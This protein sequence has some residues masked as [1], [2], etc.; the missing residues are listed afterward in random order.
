MKTFLEERS[1]I[2]PYALKELK[3]LENL[4][5]IYTGILMGLFLSI[6]FYFMGHMID[7]VSHSSSNKAMAKNFGMMLM[8]LVSPFYLWWRITKIIK[9]LKQY[10]E[11]SA[12]DKLPEQKK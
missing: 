3:D 2:S 4:I 9:S 8:F 5:Q 1:N 6:G 11:F 7:L 10:I 12:Y